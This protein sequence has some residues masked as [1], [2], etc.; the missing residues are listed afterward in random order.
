MSKRCDEL[1]LIPAIDGIGARG[2][3]GLKGLNAFVGE[4]GRRR[5]PA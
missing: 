3:W 4:G 5:E 2:R 1:S